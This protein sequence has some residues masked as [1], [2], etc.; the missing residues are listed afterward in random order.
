M[1]YLQ[2]S[3]T[4]SQFFYVSK[5]NNC[6]NDHV[7]ATKMQVLLSWVV[8]KTVQNTH[9]IN[10]TLKKMYFFLLWTQWL[11]Q[12]WNWLHEI[13]VILTSVYCNHFYIDHQRV[14]M[15]LRCMLPFVNPMN[16]GLHVVNRYLDVFWGKGNSRLQT[17]YSVDYILFYMNVP[18]HQKN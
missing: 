3:I 16:M 18:K 7:S 6:I 8:T 5:V 9:A 10:I 2:Q 1:D 4:C 11:H 13:C 15:W 12:K 17:T 14:N